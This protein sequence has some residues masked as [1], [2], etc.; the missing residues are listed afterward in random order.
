MNMKLI[1]QIIKKIA[2]SLKYSFDGLY[3][4]WVKEQS[5]RLEI[6]VSLV[7]AP[8]ALYLPFSN[9]YKL[10]LLLLL[11]LL[12]TT[13]IINSAI[14]VVVD[15]ISMEIHPQSKFAK[16]LGCASVTMIVLMNGI[17]W[18]FALCSL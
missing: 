17:A 1:L 8:L 13:E 16:D 12:L 9:F 6:Y 4:L 2:F 10:I 14:E 5:F 3:A 11:L 18:I 15:R 7:A